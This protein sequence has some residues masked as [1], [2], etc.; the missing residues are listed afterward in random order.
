M[1][2]FFAGLQCILVLCEIYVEVRNRKENK[3]RYYDFRE[4]F[5]NLCHY[6]LNLFRL[7]LVVPALVFYKYLFV[8]S[9]PWHLSWSNSSVVNFCI[10]FVIADFMWYLFHVLSHRWNVLWGAH[11]VHHQPEHWNLSIGG[12]ESIFGR[13]ILCFMGTPF[14]LTGL[15]PTTY[16]PAAFLGLAYMGLTHT[17]VVGRL[18]ILE[19]FLSTPYHHKIHHY[20]DTD[21]MGGS[22]NF[23]GVFIVWDRMFGTFWEEEGEVKEFGIDGMPAT[24]SPFNDQTFFYRHLF[25]LFFKVPVKDRLKLLFSHALPEPV[26]LVIESADPIRRYSYREWFLCFLLLVMVY[27]AM[28]IL[29]LAVTFRLAEN[30]FESAF[31]IKLIV[32]SVSV[33]LGIFQISKILQS[34]KATSSRDR[35]TVLLTVAAVLLAFVFL[36]QEMTDEPRKSVFAFVLGSRVFLALGALIALR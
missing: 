22:K 32:A 19:Y 10:A 18:G 17:R 2:F 35:V 20:K 14:A 26:P 30:A 21:R 24:S 6:N 16:Y 23:G 25:R 33:L 12:R 34:G 4:I 1:F 11:L 36:P 13:S 5:S 9:K 28:S 7:L 15:P 8:L 29:S 27:Q 31:F 3:K